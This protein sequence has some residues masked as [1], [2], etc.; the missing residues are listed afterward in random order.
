MF[1]VQRRSNPLFQIVIL[2]KKSQGQLA[3]G[4]LLHG[5]E[6][7]GRQPTEGSQA[8]YA[9]CPAYRKQPSM[10]H[11]LLDAAA[12]LHATVTTYAEGKVC[13]Q[14]MLAAAI[15]GLLW[16][17]CSE[18]MPATVLIADAL[19]VHA[20]SRLGPALKAVAAAKPCFCSSLHAALSCRKGSNVMHVIDQISVA[21][22]KQG[23]QQRQH[24]AASLDH[25]LETL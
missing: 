17:C 14:A 10:P 22:S 16:C 11:W 9:G 18:R 3:I 7:L 20:S 25:L 13:W 12:G 21:A 6:I 19:S 5:P 24:R 15:C 2:N 23:C 1:L 8:C 4:R